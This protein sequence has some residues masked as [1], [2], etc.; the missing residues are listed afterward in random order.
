MKKFTASRVPID[1]I[2]QYLQKED[3]RIRENSNPGYSL[4]GMNYYV[5]S[6]VS[7]SYWLDKIYPP[8]ISRA[9]QEGDLHIH[10]LGFLGSYCAGW[11]L[12]DLLRCGI[13]GASG[14][15]ETTPARHLSSALGQIVNFFYALQGE[16]AGAQAF[17]NFDTLLAPLIRFD[18][19]NARQ[20]RQCLQEFLFQINVP[21]RAGFQAPFT[22]ITLDMNVPPGLADQRVVVGGQERAETYGEF[23]SEMAMFHR[24]FWEVMRAGDA[25]GRAFTFPVVT[26][27]MTR[28]LIWDHP[29]LEPLWAAA[30][31]YG[32]PYFANFLGSGLNPEEIRSMCCRLRLDTR[33]LDRRGGGLFGAAPLTG[34]IG[35]VTIN[36]P[37][38]G[39]VSHCPGEF[40][41]G[42]RGVMDLARESL[43]IKRKTLERFTEQDL[44]PYIKFYLRAVK[45]RFGSY[46]RNHFSTIGV[47]GMNE[48]CRNLFGAHLGSDAGQDFAVRILTQM[49]HRMLAY[50]KQT[51]HLYNLEAVPAE[52]AAHR[53]ALEDQQRFPSIIFANPEAV[54]DGRPPFYTNSSHLPV[55]FSDD[56]F[57]VLDRQDA[58]QG[59]YTGGTVLHLY[60]GEALRDPAALKE[61]VRVVCH[62]YRLPYFTVTPTFSICPQ[63]GYL[64]GQ[65][66]RCPRC[67]SEC[68]VYS[69]VVGYLRPVAQWN[70]GKQEEFRLRRSTARLD[71]RRHP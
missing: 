46:W 11:D 29:S 50:Q 9:H 71:A 2:N 36:L 27:H 15:I 19:L 34:S 64:N 56:V 44:Y 67:G 32:I 52:S 37:R 70:V 63:C 3:W 48:A 4:Q 12:Q 65:R 10:D 25:R 39:F 43:E 41:R 31:K 1:L 8:E 30:A 24:A 53:L 28:D 16:S 26:C 20:L 7:R 57:E 17:S 66:D 35:V 47:V 60:F 59:L 61:F 40:E 54:K 68:E 13:R 51:G 45:Q 55:D 38:L 5:L 14:Q 23:G 62:Q 18:G 42:L 6:E 22:N 69:R 21:A 58:L 33:E 49:R